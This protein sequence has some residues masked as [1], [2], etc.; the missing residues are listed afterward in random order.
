MIYL[1]NTTDKLQLITSSGAAIKVVVSFVEM[2]KA[3]GAWF[4]ADR[5][6]TAIGTAT[7][8]DILAAPSASNFRTVKQMDV[9]NA[10]ASLS[11]VVTPQYN[12]NAT[13]Y[14]LQPV[15][16]AAGEMLTYIEGIGWFV[17]RVNGPRSGMKNVSTADQSLT[18]ATATYV[19]GSAIA[20]PTPPTAGMVLRWTFSVEKT[21][22]DAA[23][24]TVD[25]R[26]GTAGTTGDTSRCSLSMAAT[27]AVA[28]QALFELMA[29]IR[30][31][32]GASCIVE[33]LLQVN[34]NASFT[35]GFKTQNKRVQSSAF[36]ITPA[37]TIAGVSIT[38]GAS[39]VWTM[40]QVTSELLY[41]GG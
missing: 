13:L 19:G 38:D 20:L 24:F 4:T 14:P 41:T 17:N 32:I 22:A 1:A 33:S 11:I 15:T 36:D 3:T 21:S 23:A 26:F 35:T 30:G 9:I 29:T 28:D 6:V 18:A 8:T 37:G 25:L 12:A 7:T 34:N 16:L 10:D 31:P 5:Q 2:V 27:T 39:S 40:H